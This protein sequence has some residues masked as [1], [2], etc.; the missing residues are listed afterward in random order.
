MLQCGADRAVPLR[1]VTHGRG[2]DIHR[3]LDFLGNLLTGEGADPGSR[4]FDPQWQ[5]CHQ[6]TDPGNGSK[7]GIRWPESG[8]YLAGSL[9]EQCHSAAVFELIRLAA[10]GDG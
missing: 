7:I 6:L 3:A 2:Q 4:Q 9:D 5:A 8:V 10:L 1:Q